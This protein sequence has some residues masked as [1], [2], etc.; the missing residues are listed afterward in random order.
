MYD[1]PVESNKAST[2][3]RF[4]KLDH[5]KGKRL[6]ASIWPFQSRRIFPYGS[7]VFLLR[8]GFKAVRTDGV[9][10]HIA[11]CIACRIRGKTYDG[12]LYPRIL[13]HSSSGRRY[14]RDGG[15]RTMRRLIRRSSAVME[16]A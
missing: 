7:E 1:S 15:F 9:P 8:K 12:R 14:G 11:L 5:I 4:V 6:L 16:K 2:S 3:R 10:A 13:D